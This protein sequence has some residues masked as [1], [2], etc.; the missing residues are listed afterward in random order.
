MPDLQPL[1]ILIS[2]HR[3]A[4]GCGKKS[5]K[6]TFD[7]I[8]L[9]ACP[10][11]TPCTCGRDL[12]RVLI[13]SLRSSSAHVNTLALETLSPPRCRPFHLQMQ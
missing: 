12:Y 7:I 13:G 8:C 2:V 6:R 5:R 4:P 10:H 3:I 1:S 9:A 11:P